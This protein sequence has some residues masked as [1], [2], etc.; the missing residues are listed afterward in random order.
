M[1]DHSDVAM[2]RRK[3]TRSRTYTFT[4]FGFTP[5]VVL[6]LRRLGRTEARYLVFGRERC[7]TTGRRH[8]QG[9]VR[10]HNSR[11]FNAVKGLF[12]GL[13]A[14]PHLEVTR[15]SDDQNTTYCT[16]EGDAEIFGVP[17]VQGKRTD[18][19]DIQTEIKEGASA[20]D[21]ADNHFNKWVV[22]RR[23]FAEYRKMLH[24]P[25]LRIQLRVLGIIGA[26]GVG[27]TRYVW[28]YCQRTGKSLYIVDD[29]ELR[30]FDGYAG[31]EVA[32]IDDYRGGGRFE[33]L[34]R[35][36]DVYPLQ[37]A[38]KGGFVD[39]KPSIIFITSNTDPGSWHPE[40]DFKPLKRR[41]SRVATIAEAS[42]PTFESVRK[43]LVQQFETE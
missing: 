30:W 34:L 1:T 27:K 19:S 29:V 14:K 5:D 18:L 39:W 40:S 6:G 36:L 21:I 41:F 10:F 35:L 17:S 42:N 12:E 20:K 25:G 22:Y 28:D 23:S 33:F 7:P 38:V 24:K 26:S 32:L 15:G 2:G 8:L 3:Q 9:F 31:Q 4:I 37:V 43:F 11:A 16:K 13:G